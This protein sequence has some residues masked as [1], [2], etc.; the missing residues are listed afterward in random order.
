[1]NTTG[2][3]W[4]LSTGSR[5]EDRSRSEHERVPNITTNLKTTPLAMPMNLSKDTRSMTSTDNVA[6]CVGADVGRTWGFGGFSSLA[7]SDGW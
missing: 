1:M 5:H 7:G 6:D 4:W 2:M 3:T